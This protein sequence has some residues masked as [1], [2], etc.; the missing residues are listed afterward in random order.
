MGLKSLLHLNSQLDY[1]HT[2]PRQTSRDSLNV[3]MY[4]TLSGT[5]S[6]MG[7]L[8][9]P[10]RMTLTRMPNLPSSLAA[11]LVKPMTPALLAV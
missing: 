2:N 5:T 8:M 1:I 4:L 10:G 9:N 7:V 3:L 11:V 6:V